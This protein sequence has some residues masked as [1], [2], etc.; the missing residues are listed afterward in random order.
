MN[1]I[2][3]FKVVSWIL[4]VLLA[5]LF[6]LASIGKLTGSASANFL[7]WG[8][9]AWFAIVIG[10]AELVGAIALLVPKTTKLA[11]LGLTAI[12]FGA[13]YT[14]LVNQVG[15]QLKYIKRCRC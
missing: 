13:N 4:V 6:G 7:A 12:M 15:S 9:P 11:I 3:I 10:I 2:K 8:Y 14:H 5:T 1:K